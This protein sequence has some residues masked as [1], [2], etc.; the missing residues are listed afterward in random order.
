MIIQKIFESEVA[1][2]EIWL[3]VKHDLMQMLHKKIFFP[4]FQ[5]TLIHNPKQHTKPIELVA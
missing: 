1:M 2:K 4:N 5:G 3:L